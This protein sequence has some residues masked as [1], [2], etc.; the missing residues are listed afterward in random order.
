MPLWAEKVIRVGLSLPKNAPG[1]EYVNGM[2]EQFAELVEQETA[3][4]LQVHLYYGGVLG[5]PDERIN[6]MRRNII[7][8]T[9]GS[10]GN[11][12]TIHRDIQIF[13]MPY[14]FPSEA[15]A[16]EVLDGPIGDRMA[17]D[18]RKKTGVRVLGWWEA[19]GFKH[20]SSNDPIY[21][22][23][24]MKN[25]KMR[26]MSAV[27]AIPVTAMGGSAMPI[28]FSELYIGL[29]TG[30]VD[31]QDN[32]AVIFN[33]LKLY[34][35]QKYLTL[36]GHVYSF[37]P[38]GINDEFFLSLSKEEQ[39]VVQNAAKQ[40][41]IWN[42]KKSPE[43][44]QTAMQHAQENGVTIIPVSNELKSKFAAATQP[45]AIEWLKATVDSPSMVDEIIQ[46]VAR[47]SANQR[48]N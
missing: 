46:E 39:S 22:P 21:A 40:A 42:R 33:M 44:A 11:Y 6:Y 41:I 35:V 15:V 19:A 30:V 17:A 28:P 5:K 23:K 3:G 16:Y 1:M 27:F 18:I 13:S 7:Q 10:D 48:A 20:Y 34:E 4:E 45:A 24:D 26:V 47:V 12:A 8:M 25:K 32:S 9:D 31:G 14:L 37:G 2:Y 38:F 29:K 36:D 43:V